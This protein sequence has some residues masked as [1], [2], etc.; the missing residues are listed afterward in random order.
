MKLDI[1]IPKNKTFDVVGMG[2]NAVDFLCV[3]PHFPKF[4]TK[5]TILEYSK[6]G[7]G[8]VAT[9]LATCARLGL[10][11]KY[12]GKVGNDELGEFSCNSLKQE[13]VDISEVIVEKNAISQFAFIIVDK[14][15]GERTI[16]WY[17]DKKLHINPNELKRSSICEGK[18]LHLDTHEVEASIQAAN[19]AKEEG[20]P[21]VLDAEKITKGTDTLLKSVDILISDKAFALN[22]TSQKHPVDALNE[23]IKFGPSFVCITLGNQGAVALYKDKVFT[24]SGFKVDCKDT[25]G[26]GDV[27]H[28]AFIYGLLKDW[29]IERILE[30]ANAAAALKCK[31]LGGRKGIPNLNQIKDFLEKRRK[32]NVRELI[33]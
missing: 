4:D 13:R 22:L 16:L 17:R 12:I 31:E 23:M 24:S 5:L 20:I 29:D 33:Y 28:G 19:W 18:V 11:T 2:L 7:G 3:V 30:F 9:A 27:F 14:Q 6:Q 26:A 8:Q 32:S 10:K 15:S 1:E 25:T 21:V